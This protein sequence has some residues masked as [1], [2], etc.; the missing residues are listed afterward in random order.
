MSSPKTKEGY[1]PKEE[2]A[3]NK[4]LRKVYVWE[5][6][7]R[8]FHWVNAL[9]IILLFITGLYIG[10]PFVS[11]GIPED[12]YYSY[13]MGWMRY[14]HF[15]AAFLFTA[16]LI[17]RF[18]WFFKGN[19]Y[20]KTNPLKKEYW[21]GVWETI[22]YYL[23]LPNKKE[24]SVGHN[25]LAE[26]SYLI[27]IGIGS[28]IMILTGFYLFFEPQLESA[29]GSIFSYAAKLFGGDSFTVRSW[30]HLVAWGYI[31]FMVIHI[32]MAFR[33]DWLNK[34]GTMSSIFTGYKTEEMKEDETKEKTKDDKTA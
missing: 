33:D 5:L 11:A 28:L 14:I 10:R 27:F 20:A 34:N 19:K 24:E 15:F 23:F 4:R 30:H 7:V 13:L 32:Y 18:Y 2:A 17:F 16:N 25:K 21:R 12:A 3:R 29:F 9:S 31:I 6:P 26:L 8:L 22:K 1:F